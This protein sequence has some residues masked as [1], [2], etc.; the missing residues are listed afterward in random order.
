MTIS[1]E[2]DQNCFLKNRTKNKNRILDEDPR[3]VMQAPPIATRSGSQ[4]SMT[5]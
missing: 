2:E 4:L 5:G 1:S 3:P